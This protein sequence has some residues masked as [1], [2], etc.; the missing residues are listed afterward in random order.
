MSPRGADDAVLDAVF[1]AARRVPAR[2]ALRRGPDALTYDGLRREVE[3]RA[4]VIA[5]KGDDWTPLDAGDPVA[6][7]VDYLACRLA[8]RGSLAHGAQ[9]PSLLRERRAAHLRRWRS[10]RDES[11]VVFFSSGSVGD[12]KPVPLRDAEILAAA[13]GYPDPA[14]IVAEDRVAV[15]SSIAHV[16]GF[17]RGTIHPLLL[18]AE[19]V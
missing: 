1:A 16:F 13:Q 19:I 6:F 8:G 17:V 15:G 12:G 9:I 7:T 14:E 5:G 10:A 4:A 18:G 2:T 11:A 3:T